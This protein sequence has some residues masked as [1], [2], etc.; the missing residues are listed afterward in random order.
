MTRYIRGAPLLRRHRWW[1]PRRFPLRVCL[2]PCP[3]ASTNII[4]LGRN[5]CSVTHPTIK[6]RPE[7]NLV[8][9]LWLTNVR[10]VALRR[11]YKPAGDLIECISMGLGTMYDVPLCAAGLLLARGDK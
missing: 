5:R 7:L 11:V 2:I 10:H 1:L 6:G 4:R 8:I 9:L 3:G